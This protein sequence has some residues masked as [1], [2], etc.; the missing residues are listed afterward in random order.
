VTG[1]DY[2]PKMV[3]LD[4][5]VYGNYPSLSLSKMKLY[6]VVVVK[7]SKFSDNH[8]LTD[9][10]YTNSSLLLLVLLTEPT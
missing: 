7:S 5:F 10:A 1:V 6:R 3:M 8:D 4:N 2:V 9:P